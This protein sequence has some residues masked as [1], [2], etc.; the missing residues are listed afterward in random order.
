[1]LQIENKLYDQLCLV[2]G[3]DNMISEHTCFKK[4]EDTLIDPILVKN[5]KR[6]KKSINVVFGCRHWHHIVG[7]IA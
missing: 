6:F 7:C 2:Y 3:L 4:P 1:M 5:S